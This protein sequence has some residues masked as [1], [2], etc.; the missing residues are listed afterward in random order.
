MARALLRNAPVLLLDEATASVDTVTEQAM[1]AE[2]NHIAIERHLT[3][4]VVAH[5]LSTIRNADVIIVLAVRR[6]RGVGVFHLV[7]SKER[8]L[9]VVRTTNCWPFRTEFTIACGRFK[10]AKH[11][12]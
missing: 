1:Q 11:A 2:L 8:W 9:K 10:A 6:Y 7:C 4:I 3:S 5:R 12:R